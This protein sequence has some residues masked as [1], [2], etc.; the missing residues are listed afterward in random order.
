[1]SSDDLVATGRGLRFA[2]RYFPYTEGKS[3]RSLMKQEGDGATPIAVMRIMGLYY[4]PDRVIAPQRW[5]IPIGQRDLWC[6]DPGSWAYNLPVRAPFKGSHERL[7]RADPLY[8]IVLVLDWNLPDPERDRG[9]AIFVHQWRRRCF[10]T[11]GCLALRR[12]DLFWI[13]RRVRPG[14]KVIVR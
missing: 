8:D 11:E 10:P 4:R 9:S 2:G 5:A 6:D 3:G 12:T 14:A 1:M 7:R 13:A